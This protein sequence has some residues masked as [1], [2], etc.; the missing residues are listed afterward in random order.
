MSIH[1]GRLLDQWKEEPSFPVSGRTKSSVTCPGNGRTTLW[2]SLRAIT[3]S[4][5]IGWIWHWKT[6][7]IRQSPKE[8]AASKAPTRHSLPAA[9]RVN[10]PLSEMISGVRLFQVTV[11]PVCPAD[12]REIGFSSGF[13]NKPARRPASSARR[14]WGVIRNRDDISWA[15]KV[16]EKIRISVIAAAIGAGAKD[17]NPK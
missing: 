5:G 13:A 6:C 9:G 4:S 11:V 16:R 12:G 8:S 15:S 10:S 1:F 7:T 3:E 17:P 14:I 2:A